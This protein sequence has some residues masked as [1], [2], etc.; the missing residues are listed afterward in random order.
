GDSA[1]PSAGDQVL[2]AMMENLKNPYDT[3]KVDDLSRA[4]QE[5]DKPLL[6]DIRPPDYYAKNHLA[7]SI[8]IPEDALAERVAELPGDRD[9]PIVMLCGIGKFSKGTVLYMKSLGYRNV[10]SMKGGLNE[11]VR[12]GH[13]TESTPM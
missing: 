4:L 10:R 3:I 7:G 9:V 12:K 8:N 6:V 1:G 2:A 13:P 5:S 11:W